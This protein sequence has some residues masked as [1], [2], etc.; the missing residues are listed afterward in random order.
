MVTPLWNFD[1]LKSVLRILHYT[2]AL[3]LG[4]AG[5]LPYKCYTCVIATFMSIFVACQLAAIWPSD[6]DD[7]GSFD[8]ITLVTC[9][10]LSTGT[11]LIKF[12]IISAH[13]ETLRAM[14]REIEVLPPTAFDAECR[15]RSIVL[16]LSVLF[17]G[18]SAAISWILE[19]IIVGQ[20]YMPLPMKFPFDTVKSGGGYAVA[21]IMQATLLVIM[22]SMHFGVD[23]LC[24]TTII[25]VCTQLKDIRSE[26]ENS[27]MYQPPLSIFLPTKGGRGH[28]LRN[29]NMFREFP[30]SYEC[31]VGKIKQCVKRHQALVR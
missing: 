1:P 20:R 12:V 17:S 2:G 30:I 19:P 22:V 8:Q 15:R 16:T 28:L 5:S 23:A 31:Y 29:S 14:F 7:T 13:A 3:H 4:K 11:A 21:F 27:V 6:E 10:T 9:V 25:I 18:Y 24:C 26:I